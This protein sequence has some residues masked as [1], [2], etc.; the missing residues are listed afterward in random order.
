M[1]LH[2]AAIAINTRPV[3]SLNIHNHLLVVTT[4]G[5]ITVNSKTAEIDV[6]SKQ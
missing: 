3:K 5:N 4:D 6:S 1:S 2:V